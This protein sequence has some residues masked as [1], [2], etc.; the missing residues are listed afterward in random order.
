MKASDFY[1]FNVYF[2]QKIQFQSNRTKAKGQRESNGGRRSHAA[3][4]VRRG[5]PP[6]DGQPSFPHLRVHIRYSLAPGQH[7][8][9][10]V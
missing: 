4:D 9:N 1:P 6:A 7:G 10:N 5:F 3:P 8:W 2:A